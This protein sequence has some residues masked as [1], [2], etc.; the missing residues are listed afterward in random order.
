[1]D[2]ESLKTTFIAADIFDTESDLKQL[3]G[4]IDI[5]HAASFLHL[6]PL[7]RMTEAATRMAKMLKDK[8]GC[9]VVGRQLGNVDHGHTAG[10]FDETKNRF[11][12]NV[13]SFDAMWKKVGE[14]TGT[15]WKVDAHLEELDLHKITTQLG[16]EVNFIPP[17][18]RWLAFSVTKVA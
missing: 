2:K 18:S 10:T 12:H 15:Q 11:R 6:F 13:E 3:E 8:P 1:M 17:G 9:L 4:T 16:I 7:D 5:V 14:D